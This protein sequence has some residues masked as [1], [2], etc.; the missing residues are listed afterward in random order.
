MHVEVWQFWISVWESGGF[1]CDA[2]VVGIVTVDGAV[3]L[4]EVGG[5]EGVGLRGCVHGGLVYASELDVCCDA[6]GYVEGVECHVAGVVVGE[7]AGV[8]YG[9]CC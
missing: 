9:L 3:Y 8:D 5:V 6:L 2:D 7:K 4:V 1:G